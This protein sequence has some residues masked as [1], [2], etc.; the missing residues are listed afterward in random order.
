MNRTRDEIR[1]LRL[2]QQHVDSEME[3]LKK[4]NDILKSQI[5]TLN[6]QIISHQNQDNAIQQTVEN[7]VKEYNILIKD[8]EA[9]ISKLRDLLI[10]ERETRNRS[11]IDSDKASVSALTRVNIYTNNKKSFE[12][13]EII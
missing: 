9:E 4:E 1:K 13:F 8:K 7:K 2:L 6:L 5:E 11:Q 3:E 10:Q 12:L